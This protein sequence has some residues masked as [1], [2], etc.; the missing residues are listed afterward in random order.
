MNLSYIILLLSFLLNLFCISKEEIINNPIKTD[1]ENNPVKFKILFQSETVQIGTGD[2]A[3][4]LDVKNNFVKFPYDSYLFFQPLFVFVNE[5][6]NYNLFLGDGYYYF[7][8]SSENEIDSHQSKTSLSPDILDIQFTDY[9]M[10]KLKTGYFKE[11]DKMCKIQPNEII[12][13][14]KTGQNI[15]CYFIQ[16]KKG[17]NIDFGEV[18]DQISCKAIKY[19]TFACAFSSDSKIKIQRIL[20][21]LQFNLTLLM[22]KIFPHQV[23]IF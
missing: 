15:Y 20:I 18:D 9:I 7:T 4:T 8:I 19:G 5:A 12:I 11:I 14:G 22:M 13:Y 17:F 1:K 23:L 21:A 6:N 2:S 3:L 10:L 16:Y